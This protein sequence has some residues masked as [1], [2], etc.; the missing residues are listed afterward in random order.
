M[1]FALRK[2]LSGALAFLVAASGLVLVIGPAGAAGNGKSNDSAV[3][4][5]ATYNRFI[6]QFASN[7]AA[8][9]DDQAARAEIADT[10]RGSGHQLAF[11]RRLSTGGALLSVDSRLDAEQSRAL[12][13]RFAARGT[14]DYVEPDAIMRATFVPNDTYY[15]NQWHYYEATAGLNLPGAWDMATGAG[16]T[17]AVIDTGIT[18]H[19]DLIGNVVGGYDFISDATAARDGNGRDSNPADE[20]DWYG[21]NECGPGVPGSNSSWHGTHVSGTIAALSNNAKGVA[22]VAFD[23]KVVPARVLGKCGGTLAD[24]ADAITWASGGTVSGVPANANPAKVINMSLGGSG[25]CGS[26]YQ[27]A[28]NGAVSRGTTVVVAAGNS[29][30]NAANYQPSS[31]ANTVVVAALDRQGNRASYSNY[32]TVV[33]ISAPGGETATVAADG[34]AS[35]LNGGTTTPSTENYV[36]YQ[37]TSM[38]TPHIVGLAALM[39]SVKSLTPAEVESTLKANVRAIVGSCTGGCGAGLA[40]ATKTITALTAPAPSPTPSP[41]ATTPA[42]PSPTATAA[43]SFF[44]NTTDYQILDKKT[45]ESPLTVSER[46]GN[47]PSNLQV[48]VDIKHTFRGDL[49]IDLVA[50]DGSTYRLKSANTSD[51]ADNV[52]ATYVV[53]ASTEVANGT[54]KL[55]VWDRHNGDTGYIDSWSLQF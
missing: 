19:S 18:Q 1:T 10:G 49:Q 43:P 21:T 40:D 26:T 6:V 42:T 54:W 44:Q 55:R 24:I 39:L 31:C 38:A 50:P 4:E 37:G 46:T 34:I 28:I 22:G 41:T 33:D 53:N 5:T 36:Y 45:V 23:A 16:V 11:V 51:S 7:A 15:L 8:A 32:G 3:E 20:G 35:T 52:L 29:N 30:A 48:G 47:A 25:T 17:V 14:V 9:R 2:S 12:M 13:A 27:N